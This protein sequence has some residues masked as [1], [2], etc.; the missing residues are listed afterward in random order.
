MQAALPSPSSDAIPVLG[1]RY[2]GILIAIGVL[3]A[4]TLS[5]RRWAARGNDPDEV[6]D[7]AVWAVPAGLVGARLYHVVTDF[8]LHRGEPWYWPF[9]VWQ[10]GLGIP[11]G[12]LAGVAVGVIIAR[13]RGL[14]VLDLA[15]TMAPTVLLAQA[16]G[17]V[18]NYFNQEVFGRPSTLPWA[19]EIDESNRPPAFRDAATF[20]PTFAYEALWNLSM[21]GVLLWIDSKRVLRPGK[22]LPAYL[23][24]YFSG[25]LWIEFLRSDHANRILG[26]RINTWMSLA[27]IAIGVVWLM[28]GGLMRSS[29]T[30]PEPSEHESIAGEPVTD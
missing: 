13:R 9:Q 11:G 15:D 17:R 12:I 20:H 30:R 16:I 26:L 28:A 22:L 7:V 18:G 4:V 8:N 23:T 6:S 27:M 25:R 5:R 10:G 14:S 1:V 2:Y 24:A 3:A 21:L 19:I 29:T